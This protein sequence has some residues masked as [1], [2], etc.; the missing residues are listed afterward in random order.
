MDEKLIVLWDAYTRLVWIAEKEPEAL[1]DAR[2]I[3]M[4]MQEVIR[5]GDSCEDSSRSPRQQG[6][7][8]GGV[9]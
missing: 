5:K 6:G 9:G 7:G 2:A 8:R 3:F 1:D 4:L